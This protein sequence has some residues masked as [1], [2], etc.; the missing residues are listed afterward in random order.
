MKRM[1]TTAAVVGL[2]GALALSG[3]GKSDPAASGSGSATSSS[4]TTVV[5]T[6]VTTQAPSSTPIPKAEFITKADKICRDSNA[7]LS[8]NPKTTAPADVESWV[9]A[10]IDSHRLQLAQIQALGVPDPGA[11]EFAEYAQL[12]KKLYDQV[13]ADKAAIAQDPGKILEPALADP[14]NAVLK[15]ATAF[16]FKECGNTV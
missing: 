8:N 15:A 9:S 12:H 13:E 7:R 2:A 1:V 16:G 3:C 11:A 4:V 14:T 5:R 10:V 6:T